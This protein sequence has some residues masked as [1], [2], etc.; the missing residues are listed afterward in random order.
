[1]PESGIYSRESMRARFH[2]VRD[3]IDAEEEAGKA[4][5]EA[6]EAKRRELMERE[7]TELAPLKEKVVAHRN[8]M[9]GMQNEA[10]ALARAVGPQTGERPGVMAA[11]KAQQGAEAAGQ[12]PQ[13][14][15]AEEPDTPPAPQE[16]PAEPKPKPGR[17]ASRQTH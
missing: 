8:K 14:E 9:A 6:Y 3:Q 7:A 1:M 5:V 11:L 4:D 2:E 10:A 17:A 16:Q 12:E 15:P 13:P